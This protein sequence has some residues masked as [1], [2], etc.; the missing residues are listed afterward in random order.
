MNATKTY[1]ALIV[2]LVALCGVAAL[3]IPQVN[4]LLSSGPESANAP[5]APAAGGTATEL[6]TTAY[7]V[8]D[9]P[10]RR[11][12]TPTS[13]DAAL[14]SPSIAKSPVQGGQGTLRVGNQTGHPVRIVLMLRSQKT[15]QSKAGQ[16]QE[17]VH[18]DFAPGEGGVQGLKLSLPEEADLKVAAGDV[19]VA[20]AIDGTR[21][22]WGPNVVG[23]TPAPFWNSQTREWS[24]VLQP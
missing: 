22:Y 6:P 18:W 4:R 10:A 19:V 9:E 24:M 17:S 14:P 12:N 20:F 2:A 11:M 21:R 5:G 16:N 1:P 8:P 3:G 7:V 23:E 15:Q 13:I